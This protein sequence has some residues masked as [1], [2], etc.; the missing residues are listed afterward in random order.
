[1]PDDEE[2]RDRLR[3]VGNQFGWEPRQM[4]RYKITTLGRAF[5]PHDPVSQAMFRIAV[6]REDLHLEL[7]LLSDHRSKVL[8]EPDPWITRSYMLRR[9]TVSLWAILEVL[10]NDRELNDFIRD[11]PST[12]VQQE[13]IDDA[14]KH[15]KSLDQ[16]MRTLKSVRNELAAHL[17]PERA[18]AILDEY[19]HFEGPIR[20]SQRRLTDTLLMLPTRAAVPGCFDKSSKGSDQ[21]Q[22]FKDFVKKL[23]QAH[24]DALFCA[25]NLIFA[26]MQ[27]HQV[28]G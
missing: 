3:L 24:D 6:L 1:M 28:W 25:D 21:T 18:Q 9:I 10:Q 7:R 16:H 26:F 14:I 12:R 2:R 13:L 11:P 8:K 22:R 27:H 17:D 20:V 19:S 23:R 4:A 5:P 15:R